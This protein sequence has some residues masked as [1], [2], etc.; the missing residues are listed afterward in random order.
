MEEFVAMPALKLDAALL[1]VH[2][3]D[4]RGNV[5][6]LSPDPFFDELFACAADATYVTAEQ[7]VSTAALDMRVN[8]RYSLVERA[9]IN[10][11]AEAKFGAHPTSAAPDYHIDLKH[12]KSYV[13]S[14]VS[15]EAWTDYRKNFLDLED[16]FY[17]SAIGGAD[18]ISA[19]PKPI[20]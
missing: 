20:Y 1:H 7:V 8:F 3:A 13:D 2:R 12:L 9:L 6:T 17:L 10:G 15:V 14:A 18:A 16:V 4:Q 5:L 19:L 11:V